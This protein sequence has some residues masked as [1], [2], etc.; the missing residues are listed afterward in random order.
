MT[1][2]SPYF[3]RMPGLTLFLGA[4]ALSVILAP[5]AGRMA[6]RVGAVDRGGGRRV[7][8]GSVPRLGGVGIF[9]SC[10]V[11]GML[12][13]LK[14]RGHG[15]AMDSGTLGLILAAALVFLVG[16]YDDVAGLRVYKKLL[17]EAAAAAVLY[18]FGFRAD[19]L[20]SPF[21]G[22]FDLSQLGLPLTILWVL[23][24]TN[25]FNLIDGLDGLAAGT[26]IFAL[27]TMLMVPGSPLTRVAGVILAGSL[28]GFLF[29]NF[30]PARIF[31]GDSGSLFVGF[32]LAA[33]SL[34][35]SDKDATAFGIMVPVTVFAFP[36]MDMTYAVL[37]RYHRGIPLG[38]ADREHI[39]HK[40]LEKGLSKGVVILL[41]YG[42][43][44]FLMLTAL[45]IVRRHHLSPVW[46]FT[47]LAAAAIGGLRYLDY[48][49][50]R[51]FLGAAVSDHLAA[52]KRKYNL[53]LLRAFRRD[54][55]RMRPGR[56]DEVRGRV[57]SLLDAMDFSQ[58]E[59][60]L[61]PA[62]PGADKYIW[63]NPRGKSRRQV[64][65]SF[66]IERGG[67]I[68]GKVNLKRAVDKDMQA[69]CM[70]ETALA[71]S[72]AADYILDYKTRPDG[73]AAQ[74]AARRRAASDGDAALRRAVNL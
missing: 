47:A 5:V 51:P 36:L 71:L 17:F 56:V 7:H 44:L 67:D 23:V 1:T 50:F 13:F 60:H 46:Y 10:L 53:Y 33:L 6:V 40:L 59:I 37:R 24:V 65:L 4:L 28:A 16:V 9:L 41:I 32:T 55:G 11:T 43:N 58:A 19:F 42:V 68:Y 38:K 34:A 14:A 35:A 72:L 70:G 52:R 27:L 54:M 61:D 29:F 57:A 12:F 73:Q 8:S 20:T 66:P 2:P 62:L 63:L 15:Q 48:L 39:H 64:S 18:C 3:M 25:S 49:R 22:A 31:M 69:H 26:G 45:F 74:G 30:P 21:G